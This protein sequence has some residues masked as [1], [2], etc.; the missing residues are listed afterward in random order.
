MIASGPLDDV[1][2]EDTLSSLYRA[3]VRVLRDGDSLVVVPV[4]EP[5]GRERDA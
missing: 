3:R 2:R 4:R 5:S 1:L